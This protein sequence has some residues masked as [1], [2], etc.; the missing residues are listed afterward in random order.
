MVSGRQNLLERKHFDREG[1]KLSR[2]ERSPT[3]YRGT[4]RFLWGIPNDTKAD[5]K[6]M[7]IKYRLHK[8]LNILLGAAKVLALLPG[9]RPEAFSETTDIYLPTRIR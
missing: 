9:C 8:S 2:S 1:I 4:Q 7:L 3:G 6:N 5:K